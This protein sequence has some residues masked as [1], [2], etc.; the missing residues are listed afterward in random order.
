MPRGRRRFVVLGL[1]AL[2]AV[3]GLRTGFRAL[4]SYLD[5][6]DDRPFDPVAWAAADGNERDRGPMARD[7]FRHLPAGTP[8]D[9]VWELLGEPQPVR[10]DPRGPVDAYG[11]RL[12]HPETWAYWLGCW[13]GLGPYGFDAAFLYVHFGPDGRVVATE[14]TGG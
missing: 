4:D 9:R 1:T 2:L 12:Q 14:I 10:R 5:P 6:F 11:N 13:S 7:A 3:G 8:K